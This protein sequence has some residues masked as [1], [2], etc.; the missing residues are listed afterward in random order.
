M[1]LPKGLQSKH[2]PFTLTHISILIIMVCVCVCVDTSFR[3]NHCWVTNILIDWIFKSFCW[4]NY[5]QGGK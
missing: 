3:K 2:D 5:L 1:E 4:W